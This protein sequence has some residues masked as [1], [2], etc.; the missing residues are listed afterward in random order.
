MLQLLILIVMHI[1]H[2]HI[3]I[4]MNTH[5]R[6]MLVQILKLPI[7]IIIIIAIMIQATPLIFTTHHLLHRHQS[8]PL[9]FDHTSLYSFPGTFPPGSTTTTDPGLLN[10]PGTGCGSRSREPGSVDLPECS[11][12]VVVHEA[13]VWL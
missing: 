7:L 2:I 9:T 8:P 3:Y 6:H 1:L 13:C 5:D 11:C 4:Y 10:L 12:V